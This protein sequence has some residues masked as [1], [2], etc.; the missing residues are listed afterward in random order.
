M[1]ND[2]VLSK[3]EGFLA[4]AWVAPARKLKLTEWSYTTEGMKV[5]VGTLEKNILAGWGGDE[6]P[7]SP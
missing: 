6:M 1:L 5:R 7:E 2:K 3:S 4:C